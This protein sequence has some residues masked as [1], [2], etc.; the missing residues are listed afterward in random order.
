MLPQQIRRRPWSGPVYGLLVWAGF[1]LC[2]A[3]VLGLKQAKKPRPVER[4]ALAAD[5]LLYGLVLSEIRARPQ[6]S[7]RRRHRASGRAS[8]AP[9]RASGSGPTCFRLAEELGLDGFVANDERGVVLE[10]EGDAAAV[11]RFLERLPREAPPLATVE[12]VRARARSRSPASAGFRIVESARGGAPRALVSPDTATC[13]DCLAELLDPAD[14]RYRYPFINCTNCGPRFTIVRGVPY[15][16]PLTTM[17]GFTMCAAC[18]AEYDD[19]RDRRFHAQPNACPECGPRCGWSTRTGRAGRR[20][21]RSRSRAAAALRA[22]RDPRGQGHRRLPPRLPRRRRARGRRAAG[23][24]APRGPAVRADGA[25]T[26]TPRGRSSSSAR[27]T[28]RC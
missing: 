26:S 17:A 28:R 16:R 4:A 18:R 7:A 3:P 21:E 1:E 19:P 5:H 20:R 23:A 13:D 22:G 6:E 2:L 12:A 14:R 27:R 10:V 25:P 15:D 8:T 24:Q 11:E 9:C